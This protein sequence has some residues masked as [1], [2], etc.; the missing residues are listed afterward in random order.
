MVVLGK[1]VVGLAQRIRLAAQRIGFR[2]ALARF[3]R[4]HAS[5]DRAQPPI[6]IWDLGNFPGI[7]SRN[8]L[9][10]AALRVRGER[11]HTILCDGTPVACIRRGIEYGEM[12]DNLR[13]W[14][15]RC[16]GCFSKARQAADR[17]GLEYSAVG[18]YVSKA[19]REE[20]RRLADS[21]PL[22]QLLDHVHLGAN[23]GRMAWSS[24][25]RHM[26]GVL[27]D[28]AELPKYEAEYRQYLYAAL[29]NIHAASE[30]LKKLAPKSVLTSHGIYV[31]YAP[32]M[33]I[34]Y[35]R[36]IP[37][38]SWSSAYAERH[39]YF[40][41]PKGPNL[42]LLQGVSS[43]ELWERRAKTALT[44]EEERRLET[45]LHHRYFKA[46]ARDIRVV[47]N[48]EKTAALR[49]KLGLRGDRRVFAVFT[50]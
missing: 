41:L 19:Q 17:Y 32:P 3:L 35:Q 16:P 13:Q 50:H 29:V 44:A 36:S 23:A 45:F 15:Q 26:K 43:R 4:R 18:G 20:F 40:T 38:V 24:L 1:M 31:D 39:H 42:L 22:D 30:A 6:M 33:S 10:A 11:T 48:P 27:V 2:S 8:G 46:G 14:P 5:A 47:A 49:K 7:M 9:F 25:N 21:L 28:I 34:A 37:A 12:G